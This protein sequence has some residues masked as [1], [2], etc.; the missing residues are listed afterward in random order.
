MVA[1]EAVDTDILYPVLHT[2]DHLGAHLV[3]FIIEL[4]CIGPVKRRLDL[5]VIIVL[6]PVG[7]LCDPGV[8]P[9]RMISY[10]VEYDLKAHAVS[11][12][13]KML[14]II[15]GAELGIHALVIADRVV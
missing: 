6:I 7:M 12:F 2:L 11:L 5:A 8:I 10:P 13:D 15:Y 3:V 4:S 1:S 14:K 9:T